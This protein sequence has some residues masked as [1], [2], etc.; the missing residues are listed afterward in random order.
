MDEKYD[1]ELQA[2]K[3]K[4]DPGA[5]WIWSRPWCPVTCHMVKVKFSLEQAMKV[6]RRKRGTA[7]LFL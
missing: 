5:S 6:Q 2:S 7:L 1:S 3:L 4:S